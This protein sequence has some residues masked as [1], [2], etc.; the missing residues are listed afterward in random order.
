MVVGVAK[1]AI[2]KTIAESG[3]PLYYYTYPEDSAAAAFG[4]RHVPDMIH[5]YDSLFG[6]YPFSKLALVQSSTIFGGM[7]NSS[8]IFLPEKGASYKRGRDNDMTVAHEILHQWFGDDVTE[9]HWS[10]LWLS[11]GFATYFSACYEGSRHGKGAYQK[12]IDH[13][14][15]DYLANSPANVP[16]IDTTYH[17]LMELLNY[18]NYTKGALF[19]D[20]LRTQVGDANFFSGVRE[21]YQT[22]RHG[23]ATTADFEKMMEKASGQDLQPMF[24]R[25]LYTPGLPH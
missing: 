5:Y 1:F 17:S 11:E 18:E 15:T 23:N 22:Y 10:D 25:W 8:A 20:A 24:K 19:L 4:F 12:I 13:M 14:R 21:Y 9:S 7:E 16:V 2:T 6:P 3:L